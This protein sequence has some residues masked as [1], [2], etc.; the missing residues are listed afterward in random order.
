[1]GGIAYLIGIHLW[2]WVLLLPTFLGGRADFRQL[3]SAGYM[4]RSGHAHQ[5]YDYDA[6][7][8]FQ[9]QLVGPADIAL[10]FNHLAYEAL[11]CAPFSWLPYKQA[12]LAFLALNVALLVVCFRLIRPRMRNLANI[13]PW[14]PVAIFAGF[15]PVAAALM[16]GQDS[17]ILLTLAVAAIA[18]LENGR[19]LGA[20]MLI[21]LG[22]LKFQIV[23]PIA[24]LFFIWRRWRF[25]MG[26]TLSA[27]VVGV[28]SLLLVG[29]GEVRVYA[30]SLVSMSVH[31]S[32][33]A[34]QFK[35]GISPGSMPN[36]R[37]MVFGLGASH[38][39]TFWVQALTA[40]ASILV[41]VWTAA[42][43]SR[44]QKNSPLLLIAIVASG[45][46]SYHLLIHDL[47]I[48]FLPL[49]LILDGH[50]AAEAAGNK[51]GRRLARSAALM[52][53]AP[54]CFS[55]LPRHFWV[56]AIPALVFW[57]ALVQSARSEE[58]LIM[59]TARQ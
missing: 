15:L 31:L 18:C 8:Q 59:S 24:L 45:L 38:L 42:S 5:L 10:P 48:F 39:P 33:M 52:F 2:T 20:G 11:V 54:M 35:Y 3:Y 26:F 43:V 47:S 7:L 21:G 53:F 29:A 40:A 36:L 51:E 56:A 58:D 32:T 22:L 14:L 23:L 12:Y 34:E 50:L 57:F 16:Q 25:V 6:Q 9:R 19:D 17:I 46:V 4:V 37:G 28:T 49:V 30:E 1:M 55:Y 41:L 44:T 13:V 27:L